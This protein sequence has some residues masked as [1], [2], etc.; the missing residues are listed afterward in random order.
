MAAYFGIRDSLHL[1]KKRRSISYG[2]CYFNTVAKRCHNLAKSW[3]FET[4]IIACICFA[5]VLDGV[6]TYDTM[7][8]GNAGKAVKIMNTTL[9]MIFSAEVALKI[10]GEGIYPWRYFTGYS[11]GEGGPACTITDEG[12]WN[13]FDFGIVSIGVIGKPLVHSLWCIPFGAFHALILLHT[14]PVVYTLS[15][16]P[17]QRWF[18]WRVFFPSAP[19]PTCAPSSQVLA[20]A[21][22]DSVGP[23]GGL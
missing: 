11:P 2:K 14:A 1:L 10:I 18:E 20:R 23:R 5:G 13:C 12:L 6:M 4:L 21:A 17:P 9:L 19:P 15:C 8:T 22:D 16:R 7:N 3:P